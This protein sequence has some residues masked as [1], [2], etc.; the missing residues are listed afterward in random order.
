MQ[1]NKDKEWLKNRAEQECGGG[2]ISSGLAGC[3][4]TG[5]QEPFT[6]GGIEIRTFPFGDHY[7]WPDLGLFT[8]KIPPI[9][10]KDCEIRAKEYLDPEVDKL[11]KKL[12]GIQSQIEAVRKQREHRKESQ[13]KIEALQK[14]IAE[15]ESVL[16]KERQH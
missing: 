13:A 14:Q 7:S 11:E 8:P 3:A 16:Y 6:L 5:H 4:V 15:A 12:K 10:G 1:M 2:C 9:K